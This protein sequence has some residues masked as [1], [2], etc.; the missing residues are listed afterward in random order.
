RLCGDAGAVELGGAAHRRWSGPRDA[1]RHGVATI[2]Q[3]LNLIP[4]LTIAENIFLGRELHTPLGALDIAG[5]E[6]EASALLERLNL[7]IAPDPR[8]SGCASA[9]SSWSRS[10]RRSRSTRACLSWTSRRRP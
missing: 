8:S 4:E 10:P 1:K 2:H 7:R 9:S 3:E 5:M 6:R